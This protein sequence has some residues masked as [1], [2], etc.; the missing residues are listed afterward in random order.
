ML[1][2]TLEGYPLLLDR[3]TKRRF[4]VEDMLERMPQRWVYLTQNPS[5]RWQVLTNVTGEVTCIAGAKKPTQLL[6]LLVRFAKENNILPKRT[7]RQG[8]R[9]SSILGR[10]GTFVRL[11]SIRQDGGHNG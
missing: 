7:K 8:S 3:P 4:V 1:V 11:E 6:P 10:F 2:T 5:G 9:Y